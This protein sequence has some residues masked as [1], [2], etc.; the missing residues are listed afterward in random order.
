MN[1]QLKAALALVFLASVPVSMKAA[2]SSTSGILTARDARK[3][4]AEAKTAADH[5]LIAAY[6]QAQAQ[7]LQ[8][9][10]SEQED[11]VNYWGEKSWMVGR[12]KQPNPYSTAVS[13]AQTYRAELARVSE[14]AAFHTRMAE[15]LPAAGGAGQ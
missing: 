15:S 14:R 10:L 1:V 4:E 8:T 12:T 2:P 7:K 13:M 5:R 9:K 11:L 3:A 6:Y